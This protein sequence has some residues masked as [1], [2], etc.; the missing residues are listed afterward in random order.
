MKALYQCPER[1]VFLSEGLLSWEWTARHVFLS[2]TD[3]GS[4]LETSDVAFHYISAVHQSFI[5]LD[6]YFNTAYSYAA[7]AHDVYC[8]ILATQTPCRLQSYIKII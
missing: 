3:E 4:L 5:Y 1:H 6:L 8:Y 7:E 2:D